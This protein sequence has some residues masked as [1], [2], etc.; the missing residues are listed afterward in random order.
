MSEQN[1]ATMRRIYDDVFSRGNLDLVDEIVAPNAVDHEGGN[2]GPEGM[3]QTVTMFRTAF[4]DLSFT[5]HDLLADG[6]KTIGRIT[7]RGTHKGEFMGI[8]PTGKAFEVEAIDIV[9]FEGDKAVEH[10]GITDN[11][12]LM[13]QL[14]VVPEMGP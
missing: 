9:R 2:N 6:E 11:L 13:Q 3:K 1:K 7:I 12:A 14:G 10:W 4:P 8:A 5:V